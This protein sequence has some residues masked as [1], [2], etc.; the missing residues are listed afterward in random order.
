V[1]TEAARCG[2]RRLLLVSS[3][4]VYGTQHLKANPIAEDVGAFTDPFAANRVL[5]EAKRA[6][7]AIGASLSATLGIEVVVARGFAMSGPWLPLDADFA[8]GNFIAD[9]LAGREVRPNGS[10]LATR[11][12]LYGADVAVW[13]LT[14][15][16]SGVAGTAYNVGGSTPYRIR[17]VASLVAERA[18]GT[19]AVLTPAGEDASHD[20][21]IPDTR[22]ATALGLVEWTSLAVAIDRMLSWHTAQPYPP[23]RANV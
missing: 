13:L 11:S 7:E 22:R 5:P 3:G 12:Y 2:A 15:L 10:G 17:D 20:F 18:R 6:A 9:A 1:I 16:V 14:L 8:L 23:F 21:F 19:A 4:S